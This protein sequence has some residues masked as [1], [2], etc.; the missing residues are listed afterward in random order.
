[1]SNKKIKQHVPLI[2]NTDLNVRLKQERPIDVF[3]SL[4][5]QYSGYQFVAISK[6][7]EHQSMV[8]LFKDLPVLDDLGCWNGSQP[9]MYSQKI[10]VADDTFP[11]L[12]I[13]RDGLVCVGDPF[14]K[15]SDDIQHAFD[16]LT[17]VI[18]KANIDLTEADVQVL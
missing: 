3:K 10:Q 2:V 16:V 7:Y 15:T 18:K 9:V 6:P 4:F 12:L 11:G 14:T 17:P 1:M 8:T 13:R 5:K